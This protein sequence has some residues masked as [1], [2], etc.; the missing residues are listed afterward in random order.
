MRSAAAFKTGQTKEKKEMIKEKIEKKKKKEIIKIKIKIDKERKRKKKKEIMTKIE[1][2]INIKIRIRK[3]KINTEIMIKIKIEKKIKEE[4][5]RLINKNLIIQKINTKKKKK[6]EIEILITKIKIFPKIKSV[7][8]IINPKINIKKKKEVVIRNMKEKKIEKEGQEIEFVI[9][10]EVQDILMIN[11][12]I[13]KGL[14]EIIMII[15]EVIGILN[16]RKENQV[17][18]L[19][20][21]TIKTEDILIHQNHIQNLLILNLTLIPVKKKKTPKKIIIFLRI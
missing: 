9:I 6:K 7:Y 16:I 21:N 5:P 18:V 4:I 2:K 12:K 8:Q 3:I 17:I 13:G 11:I 19:L 14:I 1:I 15:T 10:T 20:L